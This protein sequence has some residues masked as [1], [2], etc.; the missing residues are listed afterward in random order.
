[1]KL[2]H[3]G[4]DKAVAAEARSLE[5]TVNTLGRKRELKTLVFPPSADLARGRITFVIER[6]CK[7]E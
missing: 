3:L 2:R 7:S 1:V 4:G 6:L 5:P